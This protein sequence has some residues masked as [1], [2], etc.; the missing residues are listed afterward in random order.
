[1][2]NSANRIFFMKKFFSPA[3]IGISEDLGVATVFSG[4]AVA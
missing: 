2:G 3:F 4:L 1:V